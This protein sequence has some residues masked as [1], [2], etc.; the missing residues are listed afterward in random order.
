M[1]AL[2]QRKAD[3]QRLS[4]III[5]I[6][7]QSVKNGEKYTRKRTGNSKIDNRQKSIEIT[8]NLN[9]T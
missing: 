5:G 9:M 6:T 3:R 1:A 7:A 4:V 2:P 8:G